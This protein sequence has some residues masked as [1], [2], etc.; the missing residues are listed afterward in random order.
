MPV[1]IAWACVLA[2]VLALWPVAGWRRRTLVVLLL[3]L[4]G[5]LTIAEQQ[6]KSIETRWEQER[7]NRVTAASRHL[8]S[9]LHSAL[10]RAERLA[11]AA[12]ASSADDQAAAFRVL[13]RLVPS[14]G[15]GKCVV[16]FDPQGHPWAWGGRHRLPPQSEG[17]SIASR[18]SGYYVVLEARRHSA[19]GKVAVT[20]TA[21]GGTG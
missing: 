12:I 1:W 21:G 4:A 13:D 9:D 14:A 11:E 20:A 7:E 17:D 10:H 18:A 8:D 15:P 19:N 16:V 2:A 6:L 5:V 3:G